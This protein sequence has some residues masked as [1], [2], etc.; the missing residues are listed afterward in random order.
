MSCGFEF[1]FYLQLFCI[2]S[3]SAAQLLIFFF[4][5]GL[6]E[7]FHWGDAHIFL[8]TISSDAN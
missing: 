5:L 6:L 3:H 2:T 7:N 1:C 4:T 8:K